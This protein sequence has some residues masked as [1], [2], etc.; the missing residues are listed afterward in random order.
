MVHIHSYK[1]RHT[2]RLH[3]PLPPAFNALHVACLLHATFLQGL[4]TDVCVPISRLPEVL[5]ESEEILQRSP[6]MG[7]FAITTAYLGLRGTRVLS[8]VFIWGVWLRGTIVLSRG[9]YMGVWLRGTRVL[10]RVFIWGCGLE[11]L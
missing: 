9:L 5:V 8:R 3:V 1:L 6:F 7:Q 4:V 11:G 2:H 10:S